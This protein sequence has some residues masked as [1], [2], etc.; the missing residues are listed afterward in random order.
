[1]TQPGNIQPLSL[2]TAATVG[3]VAWTGDPTA[4]AGTSTL[5]I[6]K[7]YITKVF[8]DQGLTVNNFYSY[9]GT[10]GA[11]L[12]NCYIGLYDGQSGNLLGKTSDISTSLT[13]SNASVTASAAAPITGL[14]YNQELYLAVMV[15]SG[16][17][18]SPIFIADRQYGTNLGLTSNY[19]FLVSSS[20]TLTALPSSINTGFAAALSNAPQ[21]LAVGP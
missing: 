16:S 15:G 19:R 1:M 7:C 17:T 6:G 5:T 21:Y 14:T 20:A 3:M 8:V 4:K 13:T 2:S 18:T 12:S 11:G 10:A 9:V